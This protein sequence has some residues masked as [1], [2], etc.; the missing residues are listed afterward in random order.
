MI[1][2]SEGVN[3]GHLILTEQKL[4]HRRILCITSGWPQ[5]PWALQIPQV[6]SSWPRSERKQ[7]HP[8][9][10]AHSDLWS[11][12]TS[13]L[14]E[15]VDLSSLSQPHG[16]QTSYRR[17]PAHGLLLPA[18]CRV[19]WEGPKE[20]QEERRGV[21]LRGAARK[22]EGAKETG[23]TSQVKER[24]ISGC[25]DNGRGWSVL[26]PARACL[27]LQAL[28]VYLTVRGDCLSEGRSFLSSIHCLFLAVSP[29]IGT[30]CSLFYWLLAF[31]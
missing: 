26:L 21:Q 9:H 19:F 8:F 16:C 3:P 18:C 24:P 7:R 31:L 4:V 13:A 5:A 10:R 28:P 25:A 1:K 23:S 22:H 30:I 20:I 12:H 11:H 17:S 27:R 14:R 6:K 15:T 2:Y 29:V